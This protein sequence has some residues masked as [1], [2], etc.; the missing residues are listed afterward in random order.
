MQTK[1]DASGWI[2]LAELSAALRRSGMFV[3]DSQLRRMFE[4]ADVDHSGGIDFD[5]FEALAQ[6][7]W[8]SGF[9]KDKAQLDS[10]RPNNVNAMKRVYF[11]EILSIAEGSGS[12]DV[13]RDAAAGALRI[14]VRSITLDPNILKIPNL[15]LFSLVVRV[16]T[17]STTGE[18]AMPLAVAPFLLR[19]ASF[20]PRP[21]SIKLGLEA[22]LPAGTSLIQFE[23]LHEP[24]VGAG[25]E[26][27]YSRSLF[28]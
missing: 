23:L 14:E 26:S 12:A 27:V 19:S 2:S 8:Q 20:Q 5:E 6:V 11:E 10:L 18:G 28:T 13:A 4:E 3:S 7:L 21:G 17:P 15:G 1:Q 9:V 22:L 25:F 16:T 24:L